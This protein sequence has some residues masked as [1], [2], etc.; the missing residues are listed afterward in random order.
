MKHRQ[1]IDWKAYYDE[2]E[3]IEAL[4]DR[5][6]AAARRQL[7]QELYEKDL[8]YQLH[9]LNYNYRQ[10]CSSIVSRGLRF[11][12]IPKEI[13]AAKWDVFFAADL[14]EEDRQGIY[15][16]QYKWHMFSYECVACR[17]GD[18][19]RR[20]FDICKRGAAYLFIQH[21]DEAWY[22]ENADLLAAADMDADFF[23][24]RA[25]V[26]IFDAEGKWAYARTHEKPCGP[27]FLRMKQ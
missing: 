24:E 17:K 5:E 9:I 25:D 1:I 22:I 23:F 21:T 7:L 18:N 4:G 19:A 20:A 26:Y 14:T 3:E 2:E 13:A 15:Y 10:Y 11:E 6:E 8:A 16:D 12:A 27:Y